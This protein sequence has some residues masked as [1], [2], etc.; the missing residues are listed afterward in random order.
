VA[1]KCPKC[2]S[3]NP[4]DSGFC[5]KCGTQL[6]PSENIP[7]RTETLI[8]PTEELVRGTTFAG[9]YE[10]IEEL[11]RGGMGKVYRVEDTK[12]KAEIA[13][14]LIKPEISSDR[15]T[16]ER[17]SNELKTTRMISHRNVCRMFDLGEDKGS[18]FI[19]M[20]YVSGEDL[21]SFIHRVGQLPAGKAISISMQ[22]CDGL[23]EAHRLG[24][25]HRDLKPSNIMIDKDGNARIMDFGIARSLQAKGITGA[26]IIIGTP[27]YM[28]PEQAEAK[29]TDARSDIYSLG[30]IL[31]E[32]VTGRVPFEGDTLL[33]I[34]MKHK[35]EIARNP[36]HFNPSLPDDLCGVILKCLEK[37]AGK[38]YQAA[39]EIRSELQRI[40]TGISGAEQVVP[41]KKPLSSREITVK[42]SLKKLLWPGLSI[43]VLA[44]LAAILW[45]AFIVKKVSPAP[46]KPSTGILAL[47]E[48][49]N[50]IAVLPFKNISPEQGQDYFC[51]GMTDE[52]IS[53]LS[54]VQS[55]RVISRNSAFSFKNIPKS[56]KSI[57]QELQVKN[58]LD[59]S[60]RKAGE[61]I[62]ISVQ[63]ID[64]ET[65][66][67]VW[68]ETYDK[69]LENIFDMQD[70][71][72]QAIVDA[73]RLKLTPWEAQAIAER[74]INDPYAYECYLRASEMIYS[75]SS[76]YSKE[77][78]DQ[79]YQEIEKA[80]NAIGD[81][82][83]LYSTLG[84][85]Y[86]QYVNRGINREENLKKAEE[87]AARI[88]LLEPD[89]AYGYKLLGMIQL[90][91]GKAREA[92]RYLKKAL[93]SNPGDTEAL[94]WLDF[95]YEQ[96]GQIAEARQAKERL[97]R[98]DP[99]SNP[100]GKLG[101][102]FYLMDGQFERALETF[103]RSPS[104]WLHRLFEIWLLALNHRLKEALEKIDK[105]A[106]DVAELGPE[107]DYGRDWVL[108][109]KYGL[110]G[111][112]DQA[113]ACA[114]EKLKR[115]GQTD[116]QLSWMLADC[117]ALAGEKEEAMNWLENA[118]NRGFVN[119]PYISQYNRFLKNIRGEARFKE[120]LERVKY[121]W[122]H[123]E[124]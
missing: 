21:R 3:D 11:G 4:S 96:A 89:S 28:S 34:A 124:E 52:L 39:A 77:G 106:V 68:S 56:T 115:I 50:S 2:H 109:F 72:A 92:A 103:K 81:N 40:E 48:A 69:N 59:G 94:G 70:A 23:S 95:I 80:L 5:S 75:A 47:P 18:Y 98:I 63:L 9:R 74:A 54:K 84:S 45:R 105:F 108:F 38:R 7:S 30:V 78:L 100:P 58:I 120:L 101:V 41:E 36:K 119:Y 87:T 65:D 71:V 121:E 8:T 91:L 111:K 32:M 117:Y 17:F 61:K 97:A 22:V 6:L 26:G 66:A 13:L 79:A 83:L 49:K 93:V 73:L 102:Y 104:D 110:Q 55:L 31:Y 90:R 1:T 29:D 99:V 116:E 76:S 57:A 82:V 44:I 15:K 85:L 114:T 43:A 20:E 113:L 112:K 53:K 14:K 42:F 10:I 51:D 46:E 33:T 60:V 25:V 35:G 122:E 12:I 118:V 67:P 24:V 107:V 88:F 64:A 86:Y 37:D 19:T 62:R 16:I 123:F 27:E